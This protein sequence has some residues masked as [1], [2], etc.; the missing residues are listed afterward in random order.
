MC[1]VIAQ[2]GRSL[3]RLHRPNLLEVCCIRFKDKTGFKIL[4]DFNPVCPQRGP[5]EASKGTYPVMGKGKKLGV[6]T[7]CL[8]LDSLFKNMYS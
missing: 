6:G 4:L 7:Y 8:S 2:P 3:K 1:F 5:Y